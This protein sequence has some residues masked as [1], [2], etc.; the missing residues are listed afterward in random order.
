MFL[1]FREQESATAPS[2]VGWAVYITLSGF[3]SVVTSI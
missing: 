1:Q 3:W 2:G